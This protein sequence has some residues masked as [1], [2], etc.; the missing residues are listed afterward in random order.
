MSGGNFEE[1]RI[2]ERRPLYFLLPNKAYML[3]AYYPQKPNTEP[4]PA[5]SPSSLS[6]PPDRIVQMEEIY[7]SE[8]GQKTQEKSRELK[9]RDLIHRGYA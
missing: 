2:P 1:I 7:R 8:L 4:S 9:N 5:S 3:V 6:S